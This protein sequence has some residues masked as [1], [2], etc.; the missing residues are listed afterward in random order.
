[1][2]TTAKHITPDLPNSC[3]VCWKPFGRRE[4]CIWIEPDADRLII[5]NLVCIDCARA[6]AICFNALAGA[7][8]VEQASCETTDPKALSTARNRRLKPPP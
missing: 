5:S 6:I 7:T 3:A 4:M 1:M 8:T 2:P